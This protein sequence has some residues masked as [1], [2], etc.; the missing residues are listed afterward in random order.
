MIQGILSSLSGMLRA[1]H[2]TDVAA[3]NIANVNTPGFQPLRTDSEGNAPRGRSVPQETLLTEM[4]SFALQTSVSPVP[5]EVN[6][7][8]E[9]TNLLLNQRAFEANVNALKSQDDAMGDLLDLIE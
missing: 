1:S 9:M 8:V 7:S 3:H 5:S 6:L 2:K 4:D